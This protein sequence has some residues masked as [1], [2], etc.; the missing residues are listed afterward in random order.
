[1]GE[2]GRKTAVGYSRGG[3]VLGFLPC[4]DGLVKAA[5]LNKDQRHPSK[6]YVK[7]RVYR[8]HAN[9]PFEAPKRLL[10]QSRGS[11]DPASAEPCM[12]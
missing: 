8:A 10:R 4:H 11:I 6:L 1:M 2:R 5:K 3:V 9:A 12:M 7:Q